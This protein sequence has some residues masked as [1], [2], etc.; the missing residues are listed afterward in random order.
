[1][2]TKALLLA[3]SLF[4]AAAFA[5]PAPPLPQFS[6]E[7]TLASLNLSMPAMRGARQ[8]PAKP[9]PVGTYTW[10]RSDGTTWQDERSP[11]VELWRAAQSAGTW[12]DRAGNELTLARAQFAFPALPY[13]HASREEFD[14]AL[15]DPALRLSPKAEPAELADWVSRFAGVGSHRYPVG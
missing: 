3:A 2:E 5:A 4:S 1:M 11:A 10:T 14:E 13:E 12:A 15:A 9:V 7:T 8:V 6:G